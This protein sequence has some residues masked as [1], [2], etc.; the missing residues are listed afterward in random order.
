MQ[1][2]HIL[3]ENLILTS[4]LYNELKKKSNRDFKIRIYLTKKRLLVL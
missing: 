1:V 2:T 4:K 3:Q